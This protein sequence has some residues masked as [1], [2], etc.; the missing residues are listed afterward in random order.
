M[1]VA[2][3]TDWECPS[4]IYSF[5]KSLIEQLNSRIETTIV[6][7]RCP[8]FLDPIYYSRDN[9]SLN[10]LIQFLSVINQTRSAKK[11]SDIVHLQEPMWTFSSLIYLQISLVKKAKVVTTVHEVY[12][13]N[14]KK[15]W[16]LKVYRT[17]CEKMITTCSDAIIV[18]NPDLVKY[19]HEKGAKSVFFI[20]HGAPS[21][22]ILLDK[23]ESK[24]KL[25]LEGKKVIT[26]F[27]FINPRKD[28][29]M[30]LQVLP[31]LDN[32]VVLLIAGGLFEPCSKEQKICYERLIH[33]ENTTERVK[34]T[35]YL[36]EADIATAICASD[37]ML[38]PYRHEVQSGALN[39]ALAYKIPSIAS[40][41]PYFREIKKKYDCIE[42][43]ENAGEFLEKIR[44][45]LTVQSCVDRLITNSQKYWQNN[46]LESLTDKYIHVYNTVLER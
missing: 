25:G 34:V 32:D 20:P 2:I 23:D 21:N 12:Q 31:E 6:G 39:L 24:R 29:D 11:Q 33:E 40:D 8:H 18:H 45:L 38:F 44:T 19:F 28:Y 17:F 13:D 5:S 37:I 3:I 36:D 9:F 46:N 41:L 30:I 10:N 14:E 4:G 42:I 22:P 35:G 16:L 26:I 15:N 27:G 1:R 43:A 7:V